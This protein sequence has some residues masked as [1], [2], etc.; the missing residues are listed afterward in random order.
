MTNKKAFSD[1]IRVTKKETMTLGGKLH[2]PGYALGALFNKRG[3]GALRKFDKGINIVHPTK[4]T[5]YEVPNEIRHLINV[6][7]G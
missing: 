4:G 7:E 5:L 1:V 2:V 3:D 6:I